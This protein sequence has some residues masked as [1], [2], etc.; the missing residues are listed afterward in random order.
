MPRPHEYLRIHE[1]GNLIE[2]TISLP[3]DYIRP[4]RRPRQEL[5]PPEDLEQTRE[6]NRKVMHDTIMAALSACNGDIKAAAKNRGS[7][8][9]SSTKNPHRRDSQDNRQISK[10][11]PAMDKKSLKHNIRL[12]I[13]TRRLRLY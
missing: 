1:Y 9:T 2:I 8:Q 5:I 11:H 7:T 6:H 4:D 12:S 13:L 3:W 10:H